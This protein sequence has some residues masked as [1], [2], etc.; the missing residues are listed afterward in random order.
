MTNCGKKR[1]G[2]MRFG[3]AAYWCLTSGGVTA[4]DPAIYKFVQLIGIQDL[5]GSF[6][7]LAPPKITSINSYLLPFNNFLKNGAVR[8]ILLFATSSGDPVATISPPN[9][10]ASGPMSIR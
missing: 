1:Q 5:Y 9:S 4:K 6:G 8:L 2:W 7:S 3:S 10:P